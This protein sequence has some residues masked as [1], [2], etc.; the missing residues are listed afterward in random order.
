[1]SINKFALIRYK[2]ID[3]C[4]QNRFRKWTLE[5]L[6]EACSEAVYEYEG[7]TKGVS[8]RTVQLDIQ[9]M[10]SDKLGYNAP[11]IVTDKKYYSYEEKDFSITNTPITTQDLSTLNEVLHILK[12]FSGFGYFDELNG[13][14]TRLEDKLYKTKHKGKSYIDFEKNELLK[15]LEHIDPLHKTII[16]KK[17]IQLTYQSFNARVP[18]VFIFSAYLLKEYRNRWFVLGMVKEMEKPLIL[19]LDRIIRIEETKGEKY[20]LAP[21][22]VFTYFQDIIGVSKDLNQRPVLIEFEVGRKTAPYL[23]TKPLHSSQRLLEQTGDRYL[24]SIK[25][26][27]NFELERE[28][29]GF[30]EDI[31]VLKPK[32]LV[33]RIKTRL[34]RAG[35]GYE[36]IGE[37]R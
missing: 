17:P 12:Q 33:R 34:R 31:K 2:T 24:F 8:K 15:G 21:F 32:S 19:A 25:V 11:I 28:I 3:N 5:D 23:I 1:M 22:D 9:N 18:S 27:W 10:R 37:G 20:R 35:E 16:N 26:M 4:L 30:G 14:V 29:L 13:M 36:G 6:V 7:I